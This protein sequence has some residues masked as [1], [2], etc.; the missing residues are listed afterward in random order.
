VRELGQPE[1]AAVGR[2]TRVLEPEER[3]EDR[4]REDRETLPEDHHRVLFVEVEQDLHRLRQADDH[5]Q[6]KIVRIRV[7]VNNHQP[8]RVAVTRRRKK[9]QNKH[10]NHVRRA[11]K[12]PKEAQTLNV[13]AAQ[14]KNH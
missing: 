3:Q 9:R 8:D 14:S 4:A 12:D 5:H 1:R 10:Q 2:V 6:R 7:L 13:D 11:R